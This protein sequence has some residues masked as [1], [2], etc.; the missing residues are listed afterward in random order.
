MTYKKKL[1][2]GEISEIGMNQDIP[3][4]P[5]TYDKKPQYLLKT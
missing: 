4:K 3:G 5:K 2:W 1:Q